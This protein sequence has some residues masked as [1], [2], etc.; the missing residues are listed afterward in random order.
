MHVESVGIFCLGLFLGYLGWYFVVRLGAGQ[1]SADTFASV[2]G[3][4]VGGAVLALLK[5]FLIVK[6]D[7]WWYPIGL[8]CGFLAY[9]IARW[10]NAKT[11]GGETPPPAGGGPIFPTAM[12]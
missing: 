11:P 8:V 10:I 6:T 3:V 7:V 12:G 1:V 5:E 2:V 9:V 4:F